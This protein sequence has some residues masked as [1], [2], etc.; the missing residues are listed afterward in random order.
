MHH[1]LQGV[2]MLQTASSVALLADGT[3][4]NYILIR[5]VDP[6]GASQL[7]NLALFQIHRPDNPLN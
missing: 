7:E 2:R 4:C 1:A 6:Q 3:C 5:Q